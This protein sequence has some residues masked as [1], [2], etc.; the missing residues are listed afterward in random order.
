MRILAV[1]DT[2]GKLDNL[3]QLLDEIGHIDLLI[4]LGDTEGDE[5]YIEQIAPCPV[6]IVSGNNDF[7]S[8]LPREKEL[9]I[10]GHRVFITHGHYY[11]VGMGIDQIKKEAKSR[12]C[13]I[14]MFGHTHRPLIDRG[15]HLITMNPGSLSYPRQEGHRPSY[16]IMEIDEKK[17]VSAEI[18][19]M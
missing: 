7:F 11:Y 10:E 16:I 1:S 12:G 5:D 8:D 3:I 9:D 4:H 18:I 13:D 6:E 17:G 14:V 15:L 19:Y 2:H